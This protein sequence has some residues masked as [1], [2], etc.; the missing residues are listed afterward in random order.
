MNTYKPEG[1]LLGSRENSEWLT[2][3]G[4]LRAQACGKILEGRAT[5]CDKSNNLIVD[6][7]G[8]RGIIPR[9]ETLLGDIRNIAII[10]RVG[11]PVCFKV[12]RV[13]EGS[14]ILS[15]R[16]AQLEAADAFLYRLTPG[17]IIEACITH[18][19]QFGAFAD[20]GCGLV[21]LL[22]IDSISVS[23][24]FHPRERFYVGQRIRAVVRSTDFPHNRVT[25]S[26]REL[27]GSWEQNAA[28][29]TPGMTVAGIVRG[30]ESYGIFVE[31]TENLAGLAEC[32]EGVRD[33]QTA[34]VFIKNILP[35]KMKIKLVIVDVFDTPPRKQN[36]HYFLKEG[37]IH[38]WRY[39]PENCRKVIETVF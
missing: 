5:L 26:H 3:D 14:I 2:R 4:L 38:H 9:E 23:R 8:L 10:S 16:A 22:P 1:T 28:L 13:E 11:K 18:L 29:F 35:E 21:S 19:E 37:H 33:G 12:L 20:I 24:I 15:R 7:D 6:L 25:L 34:S 17:D 27:L 30:V 32:R 31:L 39:S 36:Y